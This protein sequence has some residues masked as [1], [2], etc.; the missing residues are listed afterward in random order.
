MY[1]RKIIPYSLSVLAL[2]CSFAVSAATI[3]PEI[4][5][6]MQSATASDK[7]PVLIK[8]RA[9]AEVLAIQQQNRDK[10]RNRI[11][12]ALKDHA[13]SSQAALVEWL[14]AQNDIAGWKQ[15]W[16][17]NSVAVELPAGK[18][19]QLTKRQDIESISLDAQINA[20]LVTA[21]AP[22]TSEWNIQ[23]INTQPV[24]DAGYTGQGVVVASMDTGVDVL[25]PDLAGSWRGGNNSWF[26]PNGEHAIPYDRNGHG[27]QTM[28]I[29]S[30]A[31][32][33]GSNIGMAPGA[34]WISVKIFNDA[35]V[36]T[37]SNIHAGFQW[38]MDPDGNPATD[39]APDIVN[40]SWNLVN[41][42]GT[43][44][45]EF[46]AD[47]DMLRMADIAVLFAAGNS[48]PATASSVSPANNSG[49]V[50]TGAVD[51]T[52]TVAYFSGRGPSACDSGI[53][54]QVT[55]P[56]INIKTADLTY[57][58]LFPDA[59][60]FSSGTS[61][62][63]PHISGSFAL[64]KSA[65]VT[66]TMADIENAVRQTVSDAGDAGADMDYGWGII[67]VAAANSLLQASGPQD[68]DQD[69]FSSN[70]D[71]NDNDASIYPGA[72]EIKHDG[73][74]QDCNGF[75]L[76]IDI[77]KA[78]Y[79]SKRDSLS[80][81]AT[82]ALGKSAGLMLEG[83]GAMSW[84]NKKQLWSISVSR[85]GGSPSSIRVTGIEGGEN[86]AVMIR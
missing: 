71:C 85:V 61:Y 74:D 77:T 37:L 3:S 70:L 29:I 66:A 1:S 60:R 36:A 35:D 83:Y 19:Q 8:L 18:L 75:D 81:T 17:I 46:Q 67:N 39:D 21:G 43:C 49:V 5:E 79:N 72:P 51:E 13:N 10:R 54:P 86:T 4:S 45:N 63:V 69:G 68:A 31:D 6:I 9:K 47:I 42:T 25:H 14:S 28:S 65:N 64:L 50:S 22:S 57:S 27:T 20:P 73:I 2:S 12:T 38:L 59:Y 55:A 76:S 48:G 11:I 16:L 40:N 30:G 33:S 58:G 24:W 78:Q 82:S 34:K 15:L 84:S 62:A 26:D 32:S 56:G 80:V 44:N 7:I 52:M 23:A 53:Y 41:T